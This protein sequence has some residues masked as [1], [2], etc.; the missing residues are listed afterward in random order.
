M[1]VPL[2]RIHYLHLSRSEKENK[3]S[4]QGGSTNVGTAV[5]ERQFVRSMFSLGK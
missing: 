2:V 3:T 5:N 1:S 4:I